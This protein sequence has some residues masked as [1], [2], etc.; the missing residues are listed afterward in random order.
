[1]REAER[2]LD[3]VVA[4]SVTPGRGMEVACVV[5]SLVHD[6]PSVDAPPVAS[7]NRVDVRAHPCDQ[8]LAAGLGT[9]RVF[10]EPVWRLVV[11]HEAVSDDLHPV[12]LAE[13]DELVGGIPVERT[14]ARLHA[15]GL[16]LVLGGDGAEVRRDEIGLRIRGPFVHP[17]AERRSNAETARVGV[18]DAADGGSCRKAGCGD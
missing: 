3:E 1:M 11:P 8:R 5:E 12:L 4:D 6:V 17:L 14:F 2:E 15:L 9:V 10:E 13:G 18:L 7:D 16:H